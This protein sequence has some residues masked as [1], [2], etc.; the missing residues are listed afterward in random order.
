MS[1]YEA[2]CFGETACAPVSLDQLLAN[3]PLESLEVLGR[4]GLA[5]WQASAAADIEPLR[6][7]STSSLSRSGSSASTMPELKVIYTKVGLEE[8]LPDA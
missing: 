7:T 8:Y 3:R 6:S 1:G 4:G 5:D 2:P